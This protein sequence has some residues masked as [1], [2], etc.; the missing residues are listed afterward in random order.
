MR[1]REVKRRTKE[2]KKSREETRFD[3]IRLD[4]IRLDQ[5]GKYLN[6]NRFIIVY[7]CQIVAGS[8]LV[9]LPTSF[10]IFYQYDN[11]IIICITI[12]IASSLFL[13]FAL[14]L[15]LLYRVV[16]ITN[17][18]NLGS[19][20]WK[21][22]LSHPILNISLILFFLCITPSLISSYY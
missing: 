12:C 20:T 13:H 10:E 16:Q 4:Q 19:D 2:E 21:P 9:Y 7:S 15:E 17:G 14:I 22:E 6:N 8:Y 11:S 1:G 18:S 5:I 3:Q